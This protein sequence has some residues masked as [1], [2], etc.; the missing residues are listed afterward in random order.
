M[1]I[2]DINYHA[3]LSA[4]LNIFLKEKE[5]RGT[6]VVEVDRDPPSLIVSPFKKTPSPVKYNKYEICRQLGTP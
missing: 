4:A 1:E 6:S 3:L 5:G 2:M